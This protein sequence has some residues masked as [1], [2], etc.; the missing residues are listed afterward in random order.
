DSFRGFLINAPPVTAM[1]AWAMQQNETWA[2]GQ[3]LHSRV[4]TRARRGRPTARV[5]PQIARFFWRRRKACT[6]AFKG[7]CPYRVFWGGADSMGEPPLRLSRDPMPSHACPLKRGK[8]VV[9]MLTERSRPLV[10]LDGHARHDWSA[11]EVL[12]AV[13]RQLGIAH[14]M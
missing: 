4:L 12:E 6:P 13:R 10:R 7:G 11:P 8:A 2:I 9:A 1:A 5:T 3:C 14:S